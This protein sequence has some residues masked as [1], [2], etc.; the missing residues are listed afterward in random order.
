MNATATIIEMLQDEKYQGLG[1]RLNPPA[2]VR[3][4]EYL[5][6]LLEHTLP[7]DLRNFYLTVNGFET[8]D[9][10]FRVLPVHEVIEYKYY[11]HNNRINFA[12][13]ML[14]CDTWDLMLDDTKR[15]GYMIVNRDPEHERDVVLAHSIYEFLERYLI[16]GGIRGEF[17]LL[18]WCDRLKA[19]KNPNER[20]EE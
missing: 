12:E 15:E 19:R 4:I 5:E 18:G 13:Y 1:I 10:M 8:N 6:K 2:P 9:D 17:G 3:E 7:P 16:N 14:Y 11:L 20:Y